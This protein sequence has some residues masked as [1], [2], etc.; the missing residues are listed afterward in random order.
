V[1]VRPSSPAGQ[2]I[3][4]QKT[5]RRHAGDDPRSSRHHHQGQPDVCPMIVRVV[6]VDRQLGARWGKKTGP[7]FQAVAKTAEHQHSDGRVGPARPRRN[8]ALGR[9]RAGVASL[10]RFVPSV[11]DLDAHHSGSQVRS[12]ARQHVGGR[13]GRRGTAGSRYAAIGRNGDAACPWPTEGVADRSVKEENTPRR[14]DRQQSL[15]IPRRTVPA[16]R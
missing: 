11:S 10:D 7:R 14:P 16:I 5:P 8:S 3:T 13:G 2:Q 1:T 4:A 15:G 6:Q 12:W 9:W